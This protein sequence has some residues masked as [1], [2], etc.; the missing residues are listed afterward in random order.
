MELVDDADNGVIDGHKPRFE[1]QRGLASALVIDQFV[2][3]GHAGGIAHDEGFAL[4]VALFVERLHP[5]HRDAFESLVHDARRERSHD[6][7][8]EHYEASSP[9]SSCSLASV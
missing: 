9:S 8:E 1:Q 6:A 2:G 7:T 3:A 4:D 5:E